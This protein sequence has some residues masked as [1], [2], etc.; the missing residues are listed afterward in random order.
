MSRPKQ[1]TEDEITKD[2]A[3]FAKRVVPTVN[4]ITADAQLAQDFTDNG[5]RAVRTDRQG[6]RPSETPDPT[7]NHAR[8]D[9]DYATDLAA[10]WRSFMHEAALLVNEATALRFHAAATTRATLSRVYYCVN[11]ACGE[12]M[13][14]PDGDTPD[15]GRCQPCY[16]YR[17]THDRDAP[18]ETVQARQRK[19]TQRT[20]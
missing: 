7:G 16:T 9:K 20:A 1:L 12:Q 17:R 3:W 15:A 19:R 6:G 5:L 18:K 2:T 10:R 4:G 11:P 14:L 13:E 8:Q